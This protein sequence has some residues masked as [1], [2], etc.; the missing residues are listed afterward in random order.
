MLIDAAEQ[1]LF[2]F[3]SVMPELYGASRVTANIHSLSHLCKSV[4]LWGPLWTHSTFRFDNKNG[5]LRLLIF[6]GRV[7]IT[8]Q[9]VL[10]VDVSSTLQFIVNNRLQGYE[11][12]KNFR[13]LEI[14]ILCF[15]VVNC[16]DLVKI[17]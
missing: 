4:R 6:H 17:L 5:H 7:N 11:S 12:K 14:S 15:F 13:L 10:N 16:Y 2:E 3:V 9:L 8:H 1:M